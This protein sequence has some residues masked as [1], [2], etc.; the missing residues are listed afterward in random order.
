MILTGRKPPA[1]HLVQIVFFILL[2]PLLLIPFPVVVVIG[3]WDRSPGELHVSK[4]LK[5]ICIICPS[6][7]FITDW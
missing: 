1:L 5:H 7:P 6:M 3:I 4:K 2:R